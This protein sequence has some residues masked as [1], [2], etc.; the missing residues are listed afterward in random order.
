MRIFQSQN[1]PCNFD[2][3]RF[4]CWSARSEHP[5]L[6]RLRPSFQHTRSDSSQLPRAMRIC[7]VPRIRALKDPYTLYTHEPYAG[8]VPSIHYNQTIDPIASRI[9]PPAPPSTVESDGAQQHLDVRQRCRAGQ[10][11][12]RRLA[13]CAL[14]RPSLRSAP[15]ILR[16]VPCNASPCITRSLVA[17]RPYQPTRISTSCP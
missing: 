6:G 5:R 3:T 1:V 8:P 17:F 7:S 16:R 9:T 11:P 14:A 12:G 10:E 15:T 2:M 4:L 13:C